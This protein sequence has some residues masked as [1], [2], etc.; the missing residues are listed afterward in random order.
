[1]PPAS[2]IFSTSDLPSRPEVLEKPGTKAE[3]LRMLLDLNGKV[4]E[5]VTGVTV[6]AQRVLRVELLLNSPSVSDPYL[7]GLWCQ[8]R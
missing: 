7:A 8:V 5:V 4:C 3:T 6:G 1:M 2:K